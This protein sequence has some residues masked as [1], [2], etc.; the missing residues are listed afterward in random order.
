M[1]LDQDFANK[2]TRVM[3]GQVNKQQFIRF[4]TA[5]GLVAM[6]DLGDEMQYY[7]TDL[8]QQRTP[9]TESFEQL[10]ETLKTNQTQ[11]Y[12]EFQNKMKRYY[13]QRGSR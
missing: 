5:S 8:K 4:A 7:D 12:D 9:K 6:Q 10:S 2:M 13:Q 3:E 1:L 11:K